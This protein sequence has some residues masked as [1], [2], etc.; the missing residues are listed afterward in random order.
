M[1]HIV[2]KVYANG[3]V[4]QTQQAR[5]WREREELIALTLYLQ[6]ALAALDVAARIWQDLRH[7]K[8]HEVEREAPR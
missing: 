8:G 7:S 2:L 4:V 6:P 1:S 5:T 3:R